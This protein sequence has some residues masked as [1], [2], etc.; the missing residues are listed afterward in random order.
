MSF[1]LQVELQ[2]LCQVRL[3]LYHQDA[4]HD[5]VAFPGNSFSGNS[6]RGN[7]FLGNS[8]LGNSKVTVV[9]FPAPSL[10]ANTRPPCLRAMERTM[11][12]PRPVPF[13]CESERC[14]TR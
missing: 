2:P 12:N 3:V 11:N 10:S 8:F 13:T 6:L 5:T 14:A 9:P 1:G 7:S 4:A